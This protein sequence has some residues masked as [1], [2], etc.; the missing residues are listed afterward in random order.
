[1]GCETE[2]KR[3]RTGRSQSREVSVIGWLTLP[4]SEFSSGLNSLRIHQGVDIIFVVRFFLFLLHRTLFYSCF[5]QHAC[6]H[7]GV[8]N[9]IFVPSWCQILYLHNFYYF[10]SEHTKEGE[11]DAAKII[12][13]AGGPVVT[14]S[15]STASVRNCTTGHTSGSARDVTQKNSELTAKTCFQKLCPHPLLLLRC[16]FGSSWLCGM[17]LPLPCLLRVRPSCIH[18]CEGVSVCLVPGGSLDSPSRLLIFTSGIIISLTPHFRNQRVWGIKQWFIVVYIQVLNKSNTALLLAVWVHLR[19]EADYSW[20]T[21]SRRSPHGT[22]ISFILSCVICFNGG[23]YGRGGDQLFSEEPSNSL[24]VN[25]HKLQQ[26]K[27]WPGSCSG[28]G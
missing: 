18:L 19:L 9:S 10:S 15:Y 12:S 6:K 22:A 5:H 24:R 3:W 26:G 14:A 17:L 21:H 8:Q 13:D 16:T 28:H 27:F 23:G 11:T 7:D 25:D 2:S 4:Y 20:I 1:M